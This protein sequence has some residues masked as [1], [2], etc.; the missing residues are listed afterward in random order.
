MCCAATA[1]TKLRIQSPPLCNLGAEKIFENRSKNMNARGIMHE[2][3]WGTLQ[4]Q[5]PL[6]QDTRPLG[7]LPKDIGGGPKA[8][9]I[10]KPDTGSI[11]KKLKSVERDGA[12]KYRQQSGQ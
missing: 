6:P 2:P 11:L 3:A 10:S 8:I 1:R 4:K 9:D 5:R 7:V 12:K